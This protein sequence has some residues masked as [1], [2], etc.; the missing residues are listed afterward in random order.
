MVVTSGELAPQISKTPV[1]KLGESVR[2]TGATATQRKG[3]TGAEGRSA[4]QEALDQAGLT[5]GDMDILE[6]YVAYPMGFL[7]VLE[8]LGICEP[9]K[10]GQF[11]R[12]G[13]CSPGGKLPCS[14]IGELSRGHT[15]SGVSMAYY[16]E[17]ARQLMGKA[18]ERQVPNAKYL[19]TNAAGG[20]GMNM[21]WSVFGRDIP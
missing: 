5:L 3:R 9:G 20:S 16:V 7:R 2:Y 17:C 14:T 4:A 1:Y 21:I 15:G 11:V 18:G 19:L 8:T 12:E 10:A 13:H 6:L